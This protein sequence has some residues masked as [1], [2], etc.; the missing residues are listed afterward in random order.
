MNQNDNRTCK[1]YL[2]T[3]KKNNK[4]YVG[5]T[6]LDTVQER[7]GRE[8]KLYI[9]SPYLYSAIQKHG[10]ENFEYTILHETKDQVEADEMEANFINSLNSKDHD[11]GYNIK[12]GGRGGKHSE[13]SKKKIS[14][15]QKG[16]KSYWYGKHLSDDAKQ[17][18]SEANTGLIRTEEVRLKVIQTLVP[19]G[20]EGH[21]HTEEYKKMMSDLAKDNHPMHSSEI[22]AKR[23]KSRQM[24]TSREQE[25]IRLVMSGAKFKDIA[26]ELK[27]GLNGI[28]RVLKRNDIENYPQK[29]NKNEK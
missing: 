26:K 19:G 3:N 25:V 1:I 14:E 28:Y 24:P 17:K 4:I 21:K 5:Q 2:L 11:I 7:M 29:S 27:I 20:Y 8:G 22:I 18:I 6:W 16:E 9:N 10:Y 13:E 12:D 15:A 23:A